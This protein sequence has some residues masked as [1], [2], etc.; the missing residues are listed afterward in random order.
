M[1]ENIPFHNI[2]ALEGCMIAIQED[3]LNDVWFNIEKQKNPFKRCWARKIL[4]KAWM[5][6]NEN[7]L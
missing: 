7:D 2:S 6:L 1:Q 4:A 3:G 5:K